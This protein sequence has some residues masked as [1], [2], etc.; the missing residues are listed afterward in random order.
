MCWELGAGRDLWL[1]RGPRHTGGAEPRTEGFRLVSVVCVPTGV[2][3]SIVRIRCDENNHY[4][5]Q[6]I[7]YYGQ[8]LVQV[9]KSSRQ[10]EVRRLASLPREWA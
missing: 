1:F 5:F 6:W 7:Y 2:T 9:P 3:P 4:L 10:T 8:I